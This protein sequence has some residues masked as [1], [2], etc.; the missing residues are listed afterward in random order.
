MSFWVPDDFSENDFYDIV[1]NI[2]GDIVENVELFDNFVHPKTKRKS[3]AYH[4]T[5]RHME[6]NLTKS[7]ANEIHNDI[8]AA[9]VQ[10]LGI[11]ER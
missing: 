8:V 3:K 1:R 7:E 4:I 5:Y 9:G 6:R 2:G 11:Q 10:Q